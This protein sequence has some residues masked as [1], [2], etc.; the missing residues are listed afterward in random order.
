M[1][2]FPKRKPQREPKSTTRR[3]FSSNLATPGVS[4]AAA[5]RGSTGQQ[6]L[7]QT[8]RVA[9]AGSSPAPLHHHREQRAT[10]QSAGAPNANSLPLDNVLRTGTVVQQIIVSEGEKAVVITKIVLNLI[11]KMTTRIH[12]RRLLKMGL[13]LLY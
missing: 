4:F 7:P 12:R 3:V 1:E 13:N 9:V 2:T 10:G 6:Q 5:L 8:H 11:S